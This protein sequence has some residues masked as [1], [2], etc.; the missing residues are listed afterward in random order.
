MSN[1][2]DKIEFLPTDSDWCWVE[3]GTSLKSLG[4][5][6]CWLEVGGLGSIVICSN[7]YYFRTN[8][9]VWLSQNAESLKFKELKK[10]N[11]CL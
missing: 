4:F 9:W 3:M 5:S 2:S 8:L 7:T 6:W 11:D 10:I 1:Y